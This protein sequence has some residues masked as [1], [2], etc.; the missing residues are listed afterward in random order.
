MKAY[1]LGAG[2]SRAYELSPTG[3]R[4]PLARDVFETFSKLDISSNQWVLIGDIIN[5]VSES[6]NIPPEAFGTF[7]GDIEEI[8][9]EA[10]ENLRAAIDRDQDVEIIL[11]SRLVNQLIFLFASIVN[12]I[13]NGPISEAHRNLA[14]TLSRD[15]RI[16]TFNWDTLMDRALKAETSW[17][18][19]FGYQV[20]PHLIYRNGWVSPDVGVNSTPLLLKLHGSTNWLTSYNTME[21]GKPPLMQTSDPSTLYVYESTD[22]PYATY[23][24]RFMGGYEPFSYGY[25]PPNLLDDPGRRAPEGKKFVRARPKFPWMAE[26]SAPDNGLPSM[27]LIIPPAKAKTYDLFG[28]LFKTLWSAAEDVL[29]KAEHI[30]LIGYS[31]PRTDHQ[32]NTLFKNAFSKRKSMPTVSIVDPYPTRVAEKFSREFGI[33]GNRLFVS[34]EPFSARFDLNEILQ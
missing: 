13:Q 15:D 30:I 9:S 10:E 4:M 27:P 6:R 5:H 8:F 33:A 14:R 23:A 26:G 31:F 28:K 20:L 12:E 25:Y 3:Q 1:L 16:I 2:A 22:E 32:S 7:N 11:A 24:G 21:R 18:P 19:D 29:T 17:R 34:T